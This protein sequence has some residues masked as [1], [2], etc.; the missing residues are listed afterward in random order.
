ML[1][2]G[3]IYITVSHARAKCDSV[4][5]VA[6]SCHILQKTAQ[7]TAVKFADTN[8]FDIEHQYFDVL[9]LFPNFG[10]Y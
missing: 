7:I 9:Y 3:I 10:N 2:L 4:F 1:D 6:Y 8:V 5:S